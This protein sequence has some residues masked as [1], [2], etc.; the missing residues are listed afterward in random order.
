MT[1]PGHGGE[2]KNELHPSRPPST[3]S[4]AMRT[5]AGRIV[6]GTRINPVKLAAAREF[7]KRPTEAE[8]RAWNLLRRR[9]MLGLKFRR[10]QVIVGFI[11]DFYCAEER[12]VLEIDGAVHDAQQE[13]DHARSEAFRAL[14]IRVARIRNDDV[15][16]EELRRTLLAM[17]VWSRVGGG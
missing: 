12:L 11:A 8:A 5:P 3:A 4:E 13:Y 10:Q 14:G 17:G 16:E 6:T 1:K 2:P 7:R 9:N 15:S